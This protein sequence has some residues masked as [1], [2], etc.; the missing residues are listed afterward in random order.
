MIMWTVRALVLWR[1]FVLPPSRLR[2]PPRRTFLE[3]HYFVPLPPVSWL[4][5]ELRSRAVEISFRSFAALPLI[6]CESFA[7]I[8]A[9]APHNGRVGREMKPKGA[10]IPSVSELL[11]RYVIRRWSRN[12]T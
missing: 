6:F 5:P 10:L 12:V 7:K 11:L 4:L 1:L 8:I 2:R 3:A 9:K